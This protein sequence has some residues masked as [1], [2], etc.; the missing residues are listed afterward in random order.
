M[1]ICCVIYLNDILI[2]FET[3]E[4]HWEHMCKILCTL[5]KYQLYVKLSKCTFNR[6][7]VIFL[8]FMIKQRSIQMKQFYIDVI[9]S[10]SELKSVKNILVFLRFAK[11]Y[12]QFIKKFFQIVALLTDLIKNA[13]KKMIYSFFVMMLK[14]RKVF[15]RLKTIFVNAFI[16]KHYDWDAD[17]CMKIDA[18]NC[19]IKDVL[20]QKSKTDQWHLIAYY[21]YKFK[22]AEVW[23][24]T[25]DKELY[26]IVLNFKN[27]QHYLQSSKWFI[28]VIINH[29]N[30]RYFMIMKKLNAWQMC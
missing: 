28:C 15:E 19:K 16:L 30:L 27:W 13:K 1:N 18:S 26:A 4:Q 21:N 17:F 14:V 29:N 24:N 6:S 20:S 12:Q 2:Y 7:K 10:W 3:K 9:I 5:L 22:E 8:K 11:F 25:Y 23:W